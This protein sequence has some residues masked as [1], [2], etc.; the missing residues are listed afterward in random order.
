MI[1]EIRK[2]SAT[3][4][5][6]QP[7]GG[8][9]EGNSFT[10][11]GFP[12]SRVN[13]PGRTGRREN[14]KG[15]PWRFH[16][17]VHFVHLA[18]AVWTRKRRSAECGTTARTGSHRAALRLPGY[19]PR[20]VGNR[21][22][23]QT[24]EPMYMNNVLATHGA[25]TRHRKDSAPTRLIGDEFSEGTDGTSTSPPNPPGSQSLALCDAKV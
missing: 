8:N 25:I 15:F 5:A 3:A 22:R 4:T 2:M 19:L 14:R 11:C 7:I 21:H 16:L 24:R 1:R 6:G 20:R 17:P 9:T 12:S 10:W 23:T 13:A 18:L